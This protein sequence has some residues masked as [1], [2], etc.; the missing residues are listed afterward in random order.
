MREHFNDFSEFSLYV[1]QYQIK[2]YKQIKI[3]NYDTNDLP[4][5]LNFIDI[6]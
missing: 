6:I 4:Y 2:N 3:E 5:Y 1:P